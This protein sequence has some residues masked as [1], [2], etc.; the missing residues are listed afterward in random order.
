MALLIGITISEKITL[1]FPINLVF[2]ITETLYFVEISL[3]EQVLI[4]KNLSV[5]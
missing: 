3:Y 4:R 2:E 1:C 5:K